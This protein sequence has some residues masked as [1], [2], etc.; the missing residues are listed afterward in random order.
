M[1]SVPFGLQ[2]GHGTANMSSAGKMGIDVVSDF[3]LGT[4]KLAEVC[5]SFP[6]QGLTP[7]L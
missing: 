1:A 3:S 5:P 4:A 6:A 2:F 7:F